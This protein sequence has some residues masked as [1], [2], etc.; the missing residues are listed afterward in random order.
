VVCSSPLCQRRR[1]AEYHKKKLAEDHDYE[2]QCEHS[3]KM[4][5]ENNPGYWKQYRATRKKTHSG[6][7]TQS[8]SVDDI[9]RFLR[10][11][12]RN[13]AK[14]NSALVVTGGFLEVWFVS[15]SGAR[16]AKNSL[17]NYKV[18]VVERDPAVDG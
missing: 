2:K 18:V 4:W 14:N 3:Q 11:A 6:R 17:A 9:I 1:R 8:I 10:Q 13:S 7:D 16:S 15:C 5:R 12:K